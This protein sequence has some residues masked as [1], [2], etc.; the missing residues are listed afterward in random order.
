[1]DLELLRA[2]LVRTLVPIIVGA[3]VSVLPVLDRYDQVAALVGFAVSAVY[4]AVFRI[5]ETR[6]PWLGVFLGKRMVHDTAPANGTEHGPDTASS[7]AELPDHA[8]GAADGGAN[9]TT[10]AAIVEVRTTNADR[11]AAVSL[12]GQ[13]LAG[14]TCVSWAPHPDGSTL[15]TLRL[16]DADLTLTSTSPSKDGPLAPEPMKTGQRRT[17]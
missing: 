15:L 2:N 5:A 10:F 7:I 14:V 3:L 9:G 6:Y 8:K 12:D 1:V 4:Y 11:A 17:P 16:K 13:S